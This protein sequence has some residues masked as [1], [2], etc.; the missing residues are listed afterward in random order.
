MLTAHWG[1]CGSCGQR[2]VAEVREIARC[3][4]CE[5]LWQQNAEPPREWGPCSSCGAV[6]E[7]LRREAICAGCGAPRTATL[8]EA[9]VTETERARR[10]GRRPNPFGSIRDEAAVRER[11]LAERR[12]D[13]GSGFRWLGALGILLV[14]IGLYFLILDPGSGSSDVVSF[15]KLILGATFTCSGFALIAAEWRPR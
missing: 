14:L 6:V 13:D 8:E 12:G 2:D 10:E 4:S 15:H 5:K 9:R 1:F 3:Q 11:K 7:P